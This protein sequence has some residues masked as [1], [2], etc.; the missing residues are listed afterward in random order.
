MKSAS[1]ELWHEALS[2]PGRTYAIYLY[3]KMTQPFNRRET[4]APPGRIEA[5]LVLALPAGQYRVQWIDTKT[6]ETARTD[7][8]DHASGEARL[9]TPPFENDI[10]LQ[11]TAR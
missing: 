7:A 6:G 3:P 11:I 4:I 8:I 9:R 10:A 1:G 5:D 2:Q